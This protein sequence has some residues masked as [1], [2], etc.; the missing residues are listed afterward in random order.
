MLPTPQAM[1]QCIPPP[2][3]DK[4]PP[5]PVLTVRPFLLAC[6][7]CL[8]LSASS[9]SAP[10]AATITAPPLGYTQA[11]PLWPGKVPLATATTNGHI[12]RIYTYPAPGA[13]PHPAVIVMP[14]G[15]YTHIVMEKEGS[16][17]AQW[18]NAHGVTAFVLEYRLSPAYRYPA[19]MLDGARAIRYVRANASKLGIDPHKLGVWGFSAGGHLAGYLAAIHDPGDPA[20]SDPIDRIS[21]RPDFVI[22]S[23]ARLS[24]DPRVPRTGNME[25]ILGDK[26]TQAAIDSVDVVKHVTAD[27][28]PSFIYSTGGDQTVNS[29]N[30]S[31]YY[32]ALKRAGVPA[33]LH[34]FERGVHG[35]GMAQ[36]L[37]PEFHE[38]SIYPT[39]IQNWMQQ[40]NWM[41]Q[42]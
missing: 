29:L 6:A 24:L 30:A 23:Y 10:V 20:A 21:D 37:T 19:P 36:A 9:Q 14:G 28:T 12:P 8:S 27:T 39:L 31:A 2:I 41:P 26:P 15:G 34:I 38:L 18:L 5:M 4:L 11:I 22:L 3:C 16:Q 40:N 7:L 13:G 42:N 32:E 35:T 33:E 1:Q 25:S 17:E